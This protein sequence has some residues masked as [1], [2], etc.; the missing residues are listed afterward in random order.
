MSHV[1]SSG[2]ALVI[3]LGIVGAIV[4]GVLWGPPVVFV[5]VVVAIFAS[6]AMVRRRPS[7]SEKASVHMPSYMIP[8][9]G[10]MLDTAFAV[11]DMRKS[12]DMTSDLG[13]RIEIFVTRCMDNAIY[14]DP[15]KWGQA[16]ARSEARRA[17]GSVFPPHVVAQLEDIADAAVL[18]GYRAAT[19]L[20]VRVIM[21]QKPNDAWVLELRVLVA[22]ARQ[23]VH[24]H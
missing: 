12:L 20:D 11:A 7:I 13:L 24:S 14:C 21:G 16:E 5:C 6:F 8:P 17:F 23:A 19:P 4:G 22:K 2:P 3:G 9:Y 15:V 18:V 10:S 1:G